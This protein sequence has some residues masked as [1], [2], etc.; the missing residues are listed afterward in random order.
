MTNLGFDLR[1]AFRMLRKQPLTTAAAVLSLALGIGG[2][3]AIFSVFDAVVLR[4]LP[5]ADPDRLVAIWATSNLGRRG[6]VSPGD[7]A[8]FRRESR[9][10]DGMAAMLNASMSL[11]GGGTPEQVRVQSVSGN[12][13][14]LLGVKAIAGRTFLPS[15]DEQGPADRVLLSEPLWKRRYGGR[16]DAIGGTVT[17]AGHSMEVVG[18][19]PSSFRFD[20][21]ADL[22]LLGDRGIPRAGAVQGDLSA[23]RDVHIL[24]VIGK[25]APETPLRA[26]QAELDGH[27]ARLAR[28]FPQTNTGYGVALDPLQS[29]LVGDT[30]PVVTVL[31]AGV[32]VLLLIAAA[33]VAN[34]MLVRT[35]QRSVE[36]SMRSA[37][38]A[39]RGRLVRQIL[40]EALLLA[41]IG[42]TLGMLL[43]WWGVQ[44]IVAAAPADLARLD[45]VSLDARVL[46]CGLLLTIVTGC[47]F[48]LWPAWR[49]SSA[50][51]VGAPGGEGRVSAGRD[52]RR[53]QQILVGGELTLAQVLL[54]AAGL[55]AVSFAR[56][57]AVDPGVTTKDVVTVDVSLPKDTYGTDPVRKARFHQQVL[58]AAAALPGVERAAM[59]LT[60]PLSGAIN[61]GV[62]IEGRPAPPPGERQTMSFVPVSPGYFELLEM[63]LGSG[64]RF[65]DAERAGSEPVAI[66]N[67]SFVCR[68]FGSADPLT[69]RIGFG[70]PDQAGYWRR[71]VGVVRDAREHL[72]QPAPATAYIPFLQDGEPWNFATYAIKTALPV[73]SVASA[74]QRAVLAVASDQP[75]SRARALEDAMSRGVA[76]ERFTTLLAALF[77]GLA[78]TLAAVGAFGVMSHVVSSRRR[79][80][81]VRLALGAQRRHIVTLIVGQSLR[82]AAMA[83]GLG[84]AAAY[85]AGRAMSTLLYQVRPGDPPTLAGSAALLV[86]TAL[87]AT[88]LPVRRALAANPI[89]S[90]RND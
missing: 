68:Y 77:A 79:E 57:L 80:L 44:A 27:A 49:S 29:A 3:T 12:F 4:P 32:G 1:F 46:G 63:P 74:V 17:L 70:S 43:A 87:L 64:R 85:Y 52:R 40:A 21:P 50:T 13:F 60:A 82:V 30:R 41:A 14:T 26:A 18:V 20:T 6:A 58:E 9:S 5:Y 86:A 31:M 84:I 78:F 38:G 7:F 76:V 10:F 22:W 39:S 55:L 65:T 83:S 16:A 89:A 19:V 42:G 34:L 90:L 88:Y 69:Q 24:H 33:N 73:S 23:N 75:I 54:V 37:L 72:N 11:T 56:L 47:G 15:D 28:A 51:V 66:V 81:G 71:V 48:G 67:E 62:R 61:R 8:D 45:E 59:S 25:L 53:A 36:L 35:S 2:T